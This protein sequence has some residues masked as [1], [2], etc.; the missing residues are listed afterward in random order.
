MAYKR[1]GRWIASG[2]DPTTKQK[3]ILPGTHA[4]ERAARKAEAEWKTRSRP[5][6][7]RETAAQFAARWPT[8]YPRGRASTTITH[9]AR[10]VPFVRDLGHLKLS[11]VDRPTARAWAVKNRTAAATVRAMFADA[12]ED[13]LI[14]TNPFANLRLTGS[15]GRQDII[16]LTERELIALADIAL[17]PGMELGEYGP[18]FRAMVLFAGYVGLRPGELFALQRADVQGV[19]CTVSKAVDSHTGTI[20][21]T[22]T[23]RTRVVTIPPPAVRSLADVP[24]HPGGFLFVTPRG[25]VWNRTSHHFHWRHLRMLAA[26][27]GLDHYELR[28]CCATMLLE[29]GA[30]PMDVA[31]QLGHTDGGRL[32]MS[33]YGHP[34]DAGARSRLLGA[35]DQDVRPLRAVDDR[36]AG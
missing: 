35:W 15:R 11:A 8:D 26:R 12:L 17:S 6:V 9:A 30:T 23:G 14:A 25:K 3:R 31:V 33:T 1:A 28:H 24:L 27:P 19:F 32:V 7:G 4:T 36:E 5:T 13:G 22:K 16:A 34:T 2:Y 18:E 21:P 20:G 10:L 29:R